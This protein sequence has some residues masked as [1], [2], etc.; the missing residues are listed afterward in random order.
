ME[1][2]WDTLGVQ[3]WILMIWDVLWDPIGNHFWDMLDTHLRFWMWKWQS[4]LGYVLL[5]EFE[6]HIDVF[7]EAA[8]G[9]DTVDLM[10]FIRCVVYRKFNVFVCWWEAL[11][12]MLEGFIVVITV[13]DF[14]GIKEKS[15]S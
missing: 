10:I 7:C 9:E 3:M 8:C 5:I 1:T 11:G 13:C 14:R 12:A 15:K 4:G 6:M 2:S